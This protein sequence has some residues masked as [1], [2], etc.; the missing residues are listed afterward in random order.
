MVGLVGLMVTL[1][2]VGALLSIVMLDEPEEV[3]VPS[4]A[5]TEHFTVAP[6]YRPEES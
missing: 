5:V 1:P 4:D 6:L 2:N 3:S